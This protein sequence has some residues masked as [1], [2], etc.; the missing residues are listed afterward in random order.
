MSILCE[1]PAIL[2]KVRPAL[3]IKGGI[4]ESPEGRIVQRN[5]SKRDNIEAM[6][7]QLHVHYLDC[8]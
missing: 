2:P 7:V 1:Y 4:A 6:N 8:C 5:S 3:Q